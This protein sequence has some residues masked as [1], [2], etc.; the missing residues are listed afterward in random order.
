[1]VTD[2]VTSDLVGVGYPLH[3][4]RLRFQHVSRPKENAQPAFLNSF[5]L[6][7]VFEKPRYVMT[8][9]VDSGPKLVEIKLPVF[10]FIRC[11]C[12]RLAESL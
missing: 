1:M 7:S 9:Y 8:A 4:E 5:G 3:Y 11:N 6:K 10:I 12:L 2:H